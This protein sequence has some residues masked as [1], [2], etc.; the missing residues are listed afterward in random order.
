M[1]RLLSPTCVQGQLTGIEG[2]G[3]EKA[4]SFRDLVPEIPS[5]TYATFGLYKYPAKFIPQVIAYALKTYAQPGMSVFDPFAGYGTV[6]TVARVYEQNYELWDLNPLLK[7]LHSVAVMSPV[8]VNTGALIQ[9]LRAHTKPYNPDWSN[10]AYWYP[11]KFLP[12]LSEAWGFY[13]SLDD[14]NLKR[15]LLIP[16]IKTT[17]YFSYNDE[18]RQKLS[19]SPIARK[20]TDKLECQEWREVFY[21]KVLAGVN[22]VLA[23]Q[24]EYQR[25][26]PKPVESTIKA[27]VD[28]LTSS[29][30]KTHDI[31]ITSPP[32]LQA[33]EYIRASKMD[34]FWLGHSESS[35][36][37][38]GKKEFP[39]QD[40]PTIP[41]HSN[42]YLECLEDIKEPHMVRLF[43]QYFCGVL[44]TLS[45]LQENISKHL[46]LFLG[47]ATIRTK[48]IPIDRIFVEHFESL[49]W[50]HEATLIDTIVAKTM[51]SYKLNPA[52]GVKDQRMSTE[53]LVVLSRG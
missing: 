53:H 28:A 27:G 16:L 35:I 24:N 47:P 17:R 34:L 6:G 29:L 20:R 21:A 50:N 42:T 7:Y 52:T 9:E 31:L 46:L 37:D 26:G 22:Q 33:Q 12:L 8:E 15:I 19:R 32:Y 38:L 51:F 5:T 23:R 25:L 48:P 3:S 45:R 18:K 41:I 30:D 14:E 4:V 13:H 36:K 11:E 10:E 43:E 49:G 39:Y 1:V 40:V 2:T 44:G